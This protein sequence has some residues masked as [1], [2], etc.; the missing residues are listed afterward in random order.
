MVSVIA[1]CSSRG[2]LA[3]MWRTFLLTVLT[4]LPFSLSAQSKLEYFFTEAEK[5]RLSGDYSSAMELY[6]HCLDINEESSAVL[7]NLGSSYLL[8]REDSLGLSFLQ[9]AAEKEPGNP[10]L[11]EYLAAIYMEVDDVPNAIKSLEH[12]SSLQT[13]RSDVLSQ[14]FSMYKSVGSTDEALASLSRIETL[15]GKSPQIA[16][17][18]FSLLMDLERQDEAFAELRKLC[19]EFPYDQN[20]KLLMANQYML[21]GDTLQAKALFDEVALLEPTNMN[22]QL[23]LVAYYRMQPDKG[24]YYALRDSLLF[25]PSSADQLREALMT[26]YIMESQSD[27]TLSQGVHEAFDRILA[28]PQ[29]NARILELK[30]AYLIKEKAP[31]KEVVQ[32]MKDILQIEPDNRMAMAQLM[33]YYA[34]VN[35]YRGI[36]NLCRQGVNYYPDNLTYHFYLGLSL[37]QQSRKTEAIEAFSQA[38]RIKGDNVNPDEVSEMFSILG[39]LYYEQGKTEESFAAYDSSLVYKEDNLSCLNNYAYYL[40]LRGERLDQAE[41]MSYR[42]VKAEPANRTY[43]DTYAWILFKK[44]DYNG[45]RI[46]IDRVVDPESDEDQ[47]MNNKDLQGNV[48][49]HA[50]DIY[51]MTGDRQTAVWL[52]NIAMQKADDTTTENLPKKIRKKK[53]IK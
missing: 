18:K 22:L 37:Y 4:F 38:V 15:E 17:Q 43:L 8:L 47:L 29:K 41:E 44:G 49:E 53:Y 51:Y 3:V 14:L 10:W 42:T 36:E 5:C 19:E 21:V 13:K 34:G 28:L 52:W 23:S 48:I 30:A 35:D 11:F 39:D 40:S 27:S 25:S 9:K 6:R 7:F 2:G 50:G 33:Q 31:D 26:D 16:I 1:E 12:L 20:C 45:A 24:R 46:Y 32:T